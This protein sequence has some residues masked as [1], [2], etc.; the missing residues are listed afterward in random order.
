MKLSLTVGLCAGRLGST[1]GWG[2][3]ELQMYTYAAYARLR[4]GIWLVVIK[5]GLKSMRTILEPDHAAVLA[6]LE[7]VRTAAIE[8]YVKAVELKLD[9]RWYKDK[10]KAEKAWK[11]WK[12]VMGNEPAR[13]EGVSANEVVNAMISA[14]AKVVAEA[15]E[16]IV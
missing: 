4:L 2:D 10:A 9:A 8:A 13:M 1:S 6:A 15:R 16:E 11:A 3:G 7:P 14:V 5:L 12:A